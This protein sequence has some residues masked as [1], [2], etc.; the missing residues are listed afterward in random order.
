MRNFTYEASTKILFGKNRIVEI[1]NEILPYGNS[2]L[3]AYGG[4]SVKKSGLYD[5]IV[6]VLN[7]SGIRLVELAG[8][9]PN[10]RVESVR[11]GIRL[12]REH[13]VKFILGVGGG[14][15]IDCIKAIAMG[16]AYEGD[17]WDFYIRKAKMESVLPI[18]AV[19]TLAATGSEMNGGTVISNDA[20]KEKR[21]TGHDSLRPKFSV[22]D[23]T[24]TFTVNNWQTAAGVVDV[25]SH[26]F[27]QYFTQDKGTFVQ[28]AMAEGI[29]KTCIHYGPILLKDPENYEARAN[30]MWASSLALN[31]LT[32]TGKLSGDWATHMI[33]H[34]VSAIYDLTH[35]AGLAILFPVWMDYILDEKTAPKLAQYSRNVWGVK[36]DDDVEAARQGITKTR[37][38][39]NAMNMPASLEDVKI[40]NENIEAMAEGA[41]KFG[42]VG[43]YK[44]LGKEDVAAIL[45]KAL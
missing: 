10:P 40:T 31:G 17:V 21:A 3:L 33:E 12:C 15:V 41:C 37:E 23:P 24:I 13:D 32:A 34:E 2:V 29:L 7:N 35:G 28:D 22:L 19:L 16:V 11:E 6:E 9:Q 27:E 43:M 5:K 44:R 36:E 20:T 42:P 26:I 18:G 38:F 30:I 45:T 8:I 1:G 14:S 25:M 39:F 4:G